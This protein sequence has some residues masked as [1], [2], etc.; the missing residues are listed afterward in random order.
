MEPK[1]R[2]RQVDV[3]RGIA[4]IGVVFIH[5]S[6]ESRFDSSTLSVC[7]FLSIWFD[8]AVLAF[9][10]L[11]GLLLDERLSATVFLKKRFQSLLIPFFFYNGLYNSVFLFWQNANRRFFAGGTGKFDWLWLSWFHSPAFQLYF[12]PDLFAIMVVIFFLGQW[13]K[14]RG[15]GWLLIVNFALMV[16]FYQ[17]LGWPSQSHGPEWTKLPLYF[18]AVLLGVAG[19]TILREPPKLP[20]VLSLIIITML[21]LISGQPCL[22]SLLLPPLLYLA[23]SKVSPV[24]ESKLLQKIG[25]SS[26]AIYLWHTPILLPACT[27]MLAALHVPSMVNFGISVVLTITVCVLIKYGIEIFIVDRLKKKMPRWIVP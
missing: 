3:V 12:L 13:I 2:T 21:A 4:I 15:T 18:V 27:T 6:F 7:A 14:W 10:F 9:F 25:R 19:R 17:H 26:G 24:R 11:S 22:Q 20:F 5:S 8:W 16:M 23:V 1:I